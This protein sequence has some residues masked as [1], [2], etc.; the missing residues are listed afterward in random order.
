VPLAALSLPSTTTGWLISGLLA[1]MAIGTFTWAVWP[2]RDDDQPAQ[3]AR[4]NRKRAGQ[5]R[6]TRREAEVGDLLAQPLEPPA[7]PSTAAFPVIEDA[8]PDPPSPPPASTSVMRVA[9][10]PVPSAPPPSPSAP[11]WAVEFAQWSPSDDPPAA[12][13]PAP[14]QGPETPFPP[15]AV[16][17][18][19]RAERRRRLEALALREQAERKDPDR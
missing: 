18:E 4:V 2:Q 9:K 8:Q 11:P 1:L 6:L 16:P 7:E 13:R 3:P 19:T 17:R 12:E 14:A 10:P 5:R 15:S